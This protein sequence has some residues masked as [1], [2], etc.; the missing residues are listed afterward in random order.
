[1]SAIKAG[2]VRDLGNGG[3]PRTGN[4]VTLGKGQHGASVDNTRVP[5]EWNLFVLLFYS[6][7]KLSDPYD[8]HDLAIL[9]AE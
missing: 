2:R 5:R 7:T 6:L 3:F 1:M 8:E 4:V 9:G